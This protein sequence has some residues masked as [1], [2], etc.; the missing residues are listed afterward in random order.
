M[1]GTAS[2]ICIFFLCLQNIN[3][4]EQEQIDQFMISLD[5]T[6]N[7]CK[8][9]QDLN[10]YVVVSGSRELATVSVALVHKSLHFG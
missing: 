1:A 9:G 8:D 3:V 2:Y 6:D 4:V 10:I 7:K 5:G